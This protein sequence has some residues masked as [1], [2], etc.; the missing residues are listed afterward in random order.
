[1]LGQLP[2]MPMYQVQLGQL[3]IRNTTSPGISLFSVF[4]YPMN[5]L[6]DVVPVHQE[7]LL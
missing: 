5:D 2:Y 6:T 7:Y 4:V 1:M 3:V